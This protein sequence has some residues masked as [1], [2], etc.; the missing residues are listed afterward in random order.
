[1]DLDKEK[2]ELEASDLNWIVSTEQGRRF[3]WR[4]LS[5]CGI[6]RDFEGDVNQILK[7]SGRRQ[8]GLFL[9]SLVPTEPLFSMMREAEN[10]EIQEKIKHDN[11]SKSDS[12]TSSEPSTFEF[13]ITGGGLPSYANDSGG[14]GP[15]F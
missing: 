15:I 9:L 13:F 2:Q 6:Y 11:R 12:N 4:M 5:E 7:Q 8:V 1:M 14:S 3:Y 10:R